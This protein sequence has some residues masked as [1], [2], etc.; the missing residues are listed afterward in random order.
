MSVIH[1]AIGMQVYSQR[2]PGSDKNVDHEAEW[3]S[4]QQQRLVYVAPDNAWLRTEAGHK[5]LLSHEFINIFDVCNFNHQHV[6][7]L[8]VNIRCNV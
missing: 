5:E 1:N 3:H 8:L 4:K 7:R 6:P 2:S